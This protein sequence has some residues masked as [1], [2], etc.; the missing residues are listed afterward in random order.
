[1]VRVRLDELRYR[2]DDQDVTQRLERGADEIAAVLRERI[3]ATYALHATETGP[4]SDPGSGSV[5][6]ALA[7]LGGRVAIADAVPVEARA[8][9]RR[10]PAP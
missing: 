7:S 4:P 8:R 6:V 1:M 2:P 9:A 3:A 10:G 5:A